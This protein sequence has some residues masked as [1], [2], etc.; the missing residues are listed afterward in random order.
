M[1]NPAHP[2]ATP[3]ASDVAPLQLGTSIAVRDTTQGGC[4]P[5]SHICTTVHTEGRAECRECVRVEGKLVKLQDTVDEMM[6]MMRALQPPRQHRHHQHGSSSHMEAK[7]GRHGRDREGHGEGMPASARPPPARSGGMYVPGLFDRSRVPSGNLF[8][9]PLRRPGFSMETRGGE[10]QA[11]KGSSHESHP[12]HSHRGPSAHALES[13]LDILLTHPGPLLEDAQ[14][15]HGRKRRM[16][17]V[18]SM[19]KLSNLFDC[20]HPPAQEA[21]VREGGQDSHGSFES[22]SRGFSRSVA[23]H[24]CACVCGIPVCVC[25]V[26]LVGLV[27]YVRVLVKIREGIARLQGHRG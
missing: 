11:A 12:K 8:H 6:R 5:G 25:M 10:S 9:R 23:S 15:F 18:G 2:D 14:A 4:E 1:A 24:P 19:L 13:K 20:E 3:V 16:S 7:G 21:P 26:A 17:G 27:G 22:T